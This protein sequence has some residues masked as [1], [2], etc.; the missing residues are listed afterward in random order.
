MIE[1]VQIVEFHKILEGI[2]REDMPIDIAKFWEIV[3]YE[4][5][6][7]FRVG[8]SARVG[9]VVFNP[10]RKA[11]DQYIWEFFVN[12]LAKPHR[13]VEMNWHGQNT[14]QWLYAGGILLDHGKVSMHH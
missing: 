4:L 11:G 2:P 6:E 9:Q 5:T 7:L 8:S 14:S 10:Y 12:D 13:P 3:A 1:Q